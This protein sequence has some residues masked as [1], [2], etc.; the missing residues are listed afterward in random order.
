V[1]VNVR[2]VD[3]IAPEASGKHRYVVSHV[4]LGGDLA[5][6]TAAH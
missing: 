2:A 6:A 5:R 3:Q 1:R 4:A